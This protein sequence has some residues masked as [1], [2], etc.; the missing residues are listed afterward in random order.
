MRT[1]F[2]LSTPPHGQRCAKVAVCKRT[3]KRLNRACPPS[4]PHLAESGERK[5]WIGKTGKAHRSPIPIF[6]PEGSGAHLR[7]I[8][9]FMPVKMIYECISCL[10]AAYS[11]LLLFYVWAGWVMFFQQYLTVLFYVLTAELYKMYCMF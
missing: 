4:L 5:G 6:L 10:S 8:Q 2:E 9:N 7:V 1:S 3:D 11:R